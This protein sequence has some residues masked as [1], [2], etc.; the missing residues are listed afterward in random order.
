MQALQQLR[1]LEP[2]QAHFV[3]VRQI[4]ENRRRRL[5]IS[6]PAALSGD[7]VS[8]RLAG[9]LFD[10]HLGRAPMAE[11]WPYALERGRAA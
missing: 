9:D 3:V 4:G 11:D 10:A 6:A 1:S 2:G 8:E 7:E 5:F